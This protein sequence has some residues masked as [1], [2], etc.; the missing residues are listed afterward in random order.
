MG[1]IIRAGRKSENA[2]ADLTTPVDEP[3]LEE[4]TAVIRKLKNGRFPGPDGIPAEL[5]KCAILP[6]AK[7]LHSVF[8]SV[9]RTGH[10]PVDWRDGIIITLYK[11]KGPKTDCSSYRPITLLFVPVKVFA[12]ILTCIPPLM[13]RTRRPHQSGFAAG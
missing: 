12:H 7:A 3:C 8:L 9:W 2:T 1:S 4:V 13:D 5:L 11:G 6:V 10:V